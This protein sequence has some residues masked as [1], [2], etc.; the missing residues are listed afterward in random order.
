MSRVIVVDLLRESALEVVVLLG[1][2][3]DEVGDEFTLLTDV[4]MRRLI[5]ELRE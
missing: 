1:L 4:Q 2:P 5:F 3:R